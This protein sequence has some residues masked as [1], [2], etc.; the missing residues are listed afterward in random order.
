MTH[1]GTRALTSIATVF[2]TG[3]ALR[4]LFGETLRRAPRIDDDGTLLLRY[5]RG[6]WAVGVIGGVAIPLALAGVA[7]LAPPKRPGD[8]MAIVGMIVG[9]AL[10][11]APVLLM[12]A[13]A[14]ARVSSWGIEGQPVFGAATRVAW[15]EIT[16]VE[17]S[18]LR[19]AL[20]FRDRT[21]AAVPV[22]IMAVGLPVLLS[23]MERR[24][25]RET[26]AAAVEKGMRQFGGQ[27]AA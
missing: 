13:R 21:G 24:L 1:A 15:G 23:E 26:Y 14:W 22:P 2:L 8:M 5:G 11:G 25:R 7:L 16:A 12:A 4:A 17:Y 19:G 3:V 9:F 6:I 10:L 18:G 27:M 20:L